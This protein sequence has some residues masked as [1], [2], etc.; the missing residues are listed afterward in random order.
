[1]TVKTKMLAFPLVT[2]LCI[3]SV[4][5]V[6]HRSFLKLDGTLQG[7]YRDLRSAQDISTAMENLTNL[8]A[9]AYKIVNWSALEYSADKIDTLSKQIGARGNDLSAFLEKRTKSSADPA[10]RVSYEKILLPFLKYREWVDKT[11]AM[12]GTDSA[13]ASMMLGS[14]EEQIASASAEMQKWHEYTARRSD[15]AYRLAQESYNANVRIFLVVALGGLVLSLAVTPVIIATIIRTTR[16]IIKGLTVSSAH[17]ATTSAQVAASS[18][19]LAEGTFRQATSIEETSSSIEQMSSMTKQNADNANQ[20]NQLMS[21]TKETVARAGQSMEML[22]TSMREISTA[23]EETSKIIRTIDEIAFQTNLLALNAAVEAARAGEAGAGFAVVADEVRN[24]AMRAAAAAKNTANLIEGTV[25]R[26]KEGSE[27][28]EKTEK[29]FREVAASVARSSELVGEISA[30]S[31]EQALGIEQVNNA[32]SEM[33]KVVQ[34]NAASAEE[35]ASASEEMNGQAY[36]LKCF[37]EE[38]KSLVEGSNGNGADGSNETRG[39]NVL[40][41]KSAGSPARIVAVPGGQ[42]QLSAGIESLPPS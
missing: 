21:G 30:A 4:A 14:V 26:V 29:E 12:A 33:D 28:V 5:I 7:M 10:E 2:A 22:T 11:V 15:E 35:S 42:R 25:K 23:S 41:K 24:L 19:Q 18:Q 17:V 34:Q 8:H 27:L 37:V 1:M 32:V 40:K 20:A 3:L 9:N 16:A 39:N 38:L 6:A 13:T 31:L 36:Q